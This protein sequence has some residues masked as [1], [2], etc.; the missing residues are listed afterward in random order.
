MK[1]ETIFKITW[2]IL[3]KPYGEEEP[4]WVSKEAFRKTKGAA[5]DLMRKLYNDYHQLG[6]KAKLTVTVSEV[7]IL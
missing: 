6:F 7:E 1:L 2:C 4:A 5:E 3:E